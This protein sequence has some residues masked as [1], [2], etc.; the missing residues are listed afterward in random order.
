MKEDVTDVR[1]NREVKKNLFDQNT[2]SSQV[3]KTDNNLD[4]TYNPNTM[5]FSYT[6]N[7]I[8]STK[9]S[10]IEIPFDNIIQLEDDIEYHFKVNGDKENLEFG[11]LE[12]E[13][14]NIVADGNDITF[15]PNSIDLGYLLVKV[16]A[17]SFSNGD[18]YSGQFNI[19]IKENS[20]ND[21]LIL[22]TEK[23]NVLSDTK[24]KENFI[25]PVATQMESGLL[26][27]EDKKKLDG[28]SS[29]GEVNQNA[30]SFMKVGNKTVGATSKTDTFEFEAGKGIKLDLDN[31]NKKLKIESGANDLTT[32]NWQDDGL[33]SSFDKEREDKMGEEIWEAV[34]DSD[35]NYTID[36]KNFTGYLGVDSHIY[37][38]FMQRNTTKEPKLTILSTTAT[39]DQII[40]APIMQTTSTTPKKKSIPEG[41][42]LELV[43]KADKKFYII[44]GTG[45]GG[46]RR[47]W[48]IWI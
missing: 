13:Y 33:Q 25:I 28:I 30:Y 20:S 6:I 2:I 18:N 40:K 4:I 32:A 46:G 17:N 34:I 45:S 37:V 14:G 36:I 39:Y 8:D 31:T 44:A 15:V 11:L 19:E 35:G 42:I 16:P 1:L 10:L 26:S 3:N 48:R 22:N 5:M 7:V 41:S 29:G 23:Y 47:S 24:T 12:N 38:R 43:Y 21:I 27:V 9:E